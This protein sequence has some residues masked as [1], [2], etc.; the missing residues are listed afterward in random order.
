MKPYQNKEW[1]YDRYVVRKQTIDQ[2]S[3]EL[4]ELQIPTTPMTI[5]NWLKKFDLIKNSRK[6][7]KRSIGGNSKKKGFYH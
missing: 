1:L 6:L 4:K 5:Y 2:I 3:E 7:G